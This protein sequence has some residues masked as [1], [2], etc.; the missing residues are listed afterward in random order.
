MVIAAIPPTMPLA[1]SP[2]FKPE[3][4]ALE[5]LERMLGGL[6]GVLE[7]LEGTL[8]VLEGVLEGLE[9]TLEVLEGVLEVFEGGLKEPGVEPAGTPYPSINVRYGCETLTE[10]RDKGDDSHQQ[11]HY[12]RQ[13]IC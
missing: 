7:G 10:E 6:K 3:V 8:E 11:V 12:W 9:G 4:E 1:M 13:P 2:A 5:G